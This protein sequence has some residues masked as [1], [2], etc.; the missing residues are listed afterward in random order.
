MF[1]VLDVENDEEGDNGDDCSPEAKISG[2]NAGEILNLKGS[3]YG[4]RYDEGSESRLFDVNGQPEFMSGYQS[5]FF[6]NFA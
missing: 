3:L 2:P 6:T 4:S 5:I 1:D